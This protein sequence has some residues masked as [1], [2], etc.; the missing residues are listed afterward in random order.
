MYL[1]IYDWLPSAVMIIFKTQIVTSL[2][3][4][5]KKINRH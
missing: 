4:E 1:S 3:R 5:L 2:A